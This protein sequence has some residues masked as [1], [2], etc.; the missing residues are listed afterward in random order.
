MSVGTVLLGPEG[1]KT[2]PVAK[3][4]ITLHQ[5]QQPS[6]PA[7]GFRQWPTQW[8]AALQTKVRPLALTEGCPCWWATNITSASSSTWLP[9]LPSVAVAHLFSSWPTSTSALLPANPRISGSLKA[10]GLRCPW[11]SVPDRRDPKYRETAASP[12]H[13][14]IKR[15][16]AVNVC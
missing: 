12:V 4:T 6:S 16:G 11:I 9:S 10:I 7:F 13:T 15:R 1:N 5:P 3:G 8:M 14:L 2:E